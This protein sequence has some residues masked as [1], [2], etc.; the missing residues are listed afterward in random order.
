MRKSTLKLRIR[1][2]TLRVLAE[3]DLA[4]VAAGDAL[5]D[6][7]GPATGCQ[8]VKAAQPDTAGDP[9]TTCIQR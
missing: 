4:R 1:S 9:A 8:I 5:M 6:T 7:E 2:E 3:M